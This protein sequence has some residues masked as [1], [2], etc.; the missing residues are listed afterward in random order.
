M[1]FYFAWLKLKTVYFTLENIFNGIYFSEKIYLAK[2]ISV[3]YEHNIEY[4]K[5]REVDNMSDF[6]SFLDKTLTQIDVEAIK[7]EDN[8]VYEYDIYKEIRELVIAARDRAGF[9]QKELAAKSGLT[10]SNISNI[11]KGTTRPTIDSLKKI[12]DATG[13]RLVIQFVDREVML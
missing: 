13:R 1:L 6:Q 7:E 4:I 11:E 12:A 3:D 2:Y 10:Q 8:E 9:T 5:C